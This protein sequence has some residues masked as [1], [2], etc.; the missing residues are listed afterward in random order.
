MNSITKTNDR[1]E[2]HYDAV[3]IGSGYGGGVAASRLSRM[4]LRVCVLEKGRQWRP[5][6]YANSIT[7]L[8]SR[9][10]LS[11]RRVNLGAENSLFDC[12][13]GKE[14][15]VL[16][17]CGLGGGSLVN[18]GL[19]VRP[20]PFVFEQKEWPEQIRKDKFLDKG[21]ERAEKMLGVAHC[22]NGS[23]LARFKSLQTCA[24]NLDS[25]K[26]PKAELVPSTINYTPGTNLSNVQQ[27]ACVQCGDCWTGCNMGAKN[28]VTLTYLTDAHNFG[29]SLYTGIRV[30]FVRKAN[31][32]WRLFFEHLDEE[33]GKPKSKGSLTARIIVFSAGVLGTTEILMRSKQKG[34]TLSKQLG[35]GF[36][37]NGDDL[38]FGHDLPEPVNGIAVGFPSRA[39]L[40]QPVGPNA[41]GMISLQD[42]DEPRS[43]IKL[44][45][46]TM[47]PLM[48]TLAP[49][50]S[51]LLGKPVRAVKLLLSGAYK[52]AL[53]RTQCFYIVGHDDAGGELTLHRNRLLLSWPSVADQPVFG[54][55]ETV[56]TGIFEKLGADYMQNP[57]RDTIL[58]G[59]LI[60]VHPL[61][62]CSMGCNVEEGVV[63]HQGR[64]FD[65]ANG[66][67][68]Q[69]GP[70]T[71]HKGLYVLDGSII[72]TSLGANPLLTI[73]ALS[74]RA[75]YLFAKEHNLDFDDTPHK[76]APLRDAFM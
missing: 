59:K 54:K 16:T 20:S 21:F 24:N 53:T 65:P 45:A 75:M 50:K 62:G 9:L 3:V 51:L 74:E 8:M 27:S 46:G 39:N 68:H 26:N 13:L 32:Q 18:A 15:H 34:L 23:R 43:Q 5:G 48:A 41:I 2:D 4:G 67:K 44:Q 1:L 69:A 52:G 31:N 72:P 56:L 64:L 14:M 60:T 7:G 33:T 40:E 71:T 36:S 47:I 11:G 25:K 55:A 30:N 17:G 73:A 29:A 12:R 28:T 10:H 19:A 38:A 37:A 66:K 22:P 57:V 76:N 63:D 61:G 70:T 49:L 42:N 6:D 35:K 58:G